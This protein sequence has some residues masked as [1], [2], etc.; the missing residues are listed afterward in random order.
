[1]KYI[2]DIINKILEWSLKRNARKQFDKAM[3]EYRDS[4]NT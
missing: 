2:S 4:D 3:L 1:M